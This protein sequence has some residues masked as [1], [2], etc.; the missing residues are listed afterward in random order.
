[1]TWAGSFTLTEEKTAN[2]QAKNGEV[3]PV[4]TS[5]G[6]WTLSAPLNLGRSTSFGLIMIDQVNIL[7]ILVAELVQ[8]P[9]RKLPNVTTFD[10]LIDGALYFVYDGA[11][12]RLV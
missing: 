4:N 3:V 1:M 6:S 2:Y 9:V 10:V 7:T 8:Q 12:W 11:V 5:G